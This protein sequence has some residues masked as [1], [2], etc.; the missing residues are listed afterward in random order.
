M[1]RAWG[2]GTQ[3]EEAALVALTAASQ[4]AAQV[5][6]PF[7][8]DAESSLGDAESSLGDMLR[9][10]WVTLRARCGHEPEEP[11]GYAAGRGSQ[12]GLGG[13]VRE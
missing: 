11:E 13:R 4:S 6:F 8:G 9:A 10:R 12:R 5:R 2:D 1:L 7:L 3:G